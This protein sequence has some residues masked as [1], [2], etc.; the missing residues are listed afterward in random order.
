VTKAEIQALITRAEALQNLPEGIAMVHRKPSHL[1]E[2]WPGKRLTKLQQH[3]LWT[4]ISRE[5]PIQFKIRVYRDPYP[6][7][8]IARADSAEPDVRVDFAELDELLG[9]IDEQMR[10]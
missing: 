5:L 1:V 10:P 8:P 9:A 2:Y 7:E 3:N 4:A 6:D